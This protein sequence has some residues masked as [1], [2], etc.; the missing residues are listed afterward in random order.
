MEHGLPQH[1][2]QSSAK[3]TSPELS[4]RCQAAS[5]AAR[6]FGTSTPEHCLQSGATDLSFCDQKRMGDMTS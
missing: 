6:S 3:K 2:G 1:P 5:A 4:G